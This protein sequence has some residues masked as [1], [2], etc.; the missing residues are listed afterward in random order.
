MIAKWLKNALYQ[1]GLSQA[2]LARQ[3][4]AR[5][6]PVDR[7]AVNKMLL[8]RAT[9]KIKPRKVSGPE[10]IAISDI[11]GC[12]LP[13]GVMPGS[14]LLETSEHIDSET[15]AAN[16]GV[17]VQAPWQHEPPFEEAIAQVTGHIGGGS[18][19]E[20]ITLSAG[21]MQTLEPV[22]AWWR[23]PQ[24]ALSGF[25]FQGALPRHIVGWFMDGSSMEPTIQRTDVVFIDTRRVKPD[26]DGIFAVDFGEGRT[27]KRIQTKKT[28][29][30]IRY[31]LKS[32]NAN[33][34]P[35]MEYDVDEVKIIGRYLF[36]FTVY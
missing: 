33:H 22:A 34:F 26:P 25:G 31:V 36:R 30:G 11:T 2:E 21:E 18:T 32:D 9:S 7:A 8:E 1:S 13:A 14:K 35:P 4:T 29:T 20:V 12:P 19:G 10:L 15:V 28:D 27:L 6:F 16:L 24:Q 3:M 17:D 23:V 5:G